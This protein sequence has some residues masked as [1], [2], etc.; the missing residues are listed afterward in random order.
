LRSAP[1]CADD[2]AKPFLV[3]IEERAAEGVQTPAALSSGEPDDG[4]AVETERWD[5]VADGLN[6]RWH[7]ARDLGPQALQGHAL[8][9][10]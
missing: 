7:E 4:P 6:R 2:T 3:R 5:A 1:R 10:G 9:V 8:I